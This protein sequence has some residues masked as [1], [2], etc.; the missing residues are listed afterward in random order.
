[1]ARCIHGHGL[2]VH[3]KRKA[4]GSSLSNAEVLCESCRKMADSRDTSGVTPASF[5]EETKARA[6]AHAH[7]R[8]ECVKLGCH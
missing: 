8:C 6:L 7:T 1:M 5:S 3:H 4:G 2:E